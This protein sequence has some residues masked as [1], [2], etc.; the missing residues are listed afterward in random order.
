MYTF[1]SFSLKKDITIFI[2]QNLVRRAHK[3]F[4]KRKIIQSNLSCVTFQ[5]DHKEGFIHSKAN[6]CRLFILLQ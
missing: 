6:G 1:L 5:K 4:V 2:S 3:D